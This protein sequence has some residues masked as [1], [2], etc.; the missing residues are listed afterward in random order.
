M[1]E[2]IKTALKAIQALLNKCVKK[3][4]GITPDVNGNV[5]IGWQEIPDKPSISAGTGDKSIEEGSDTTARGRYSHAEGWRTSA[6]GQASHAEGIDAVASNDFSHA[7]GSHTGASGYASHAEGSYTRAKG[8]SSHA[9]G[10]NTWANGDYSHAEGRY[11]AASGNHSHAEGY[12]TVA[13][14]NY[15]HVQGKYNIEDNTSTYAHIVGNGTFTTKRSNAH[16]LDW[17]GNAWFAGTVEGT[18]IILTSPS[19]TRFKI[20]VDDTGTLTATEVV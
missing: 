12:E 19:G 15:Q 4:N 2:A 16:T 9:E 5:Q 14:G 11:S 1:L 3:I 6:T 17:S 13:S 18:G 10:D 8:E 7:E 20:T